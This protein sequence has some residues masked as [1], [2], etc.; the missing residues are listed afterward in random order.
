MSRNPH[1]QG[2]RR[3]SFRICTE[4]AKSLNGQIRKDEVNAYFENL[5]G[6]SNETLAQ[7][8]KQRRTLLA[9]MSVPG[10]GIRKDYAG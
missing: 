10:E 4:N 5:T 1:V 8:I 6:V 3:Q 7:Q 9:R 2:M